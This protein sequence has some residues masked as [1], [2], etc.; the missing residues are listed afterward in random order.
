VLVWAAERH[1][2]VGPPFPLP[3]LFQ[4]PTPAAYPSVPLTSP[5]IS[6]TRRL[7][8]IRKPGSVNQ[9][10]IFTNNKLPDGEVGYPGGIFDPLGYSKGDMATLKLKEIK[11]GRLAMLAFVGFCA[12]VRACVLGAVLC[13]S[14]WQASVWTCWLDGVAVKEKFS[15]RACSCCCWCCAHLRYRC[16]VCDPH[17]L[18]PPARPPCRTWPPTWLTPGAPLC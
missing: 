8:D 7:Q 1:T 3:L 16:C 15:V 18:P 14:C 2:E 4:T 10:P 5:S 13:S 17:R 6:S 9:D 11:N 12:Q